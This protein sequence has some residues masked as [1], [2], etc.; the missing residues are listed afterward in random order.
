M[1][2]VAETVALLGGIGGVEWGRVHQGGGVTWTRVFNNYILISRTTIY[3]T[4]NL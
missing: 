2:Y 4:N 3:N 1:W